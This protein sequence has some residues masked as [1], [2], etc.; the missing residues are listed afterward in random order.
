MV[1]SVKWVV[2]NLKNQGLT[3]IWDFSSGR[4]GWRNAAN[5]GP[6]VAGRK[7]DDD[8]VEVLRHRRRRRRR[9]VARQWT[10]SAELSSAW[11]RRLKDLRQGHS[12]RKLEFKSK[13]N[14]RQAKVFGPGSFVQMWFDQ[15]TNDPL[16]Q[17]NDLLNNFQRC[18]LTTDQTYITAKLFKLLAIACF[19][20]RGHFY[21]VLSCKLQL[22]NRLF[23][24]DHRI[25]DWP[26]Y[27]CQPSGFL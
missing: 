14:L 7:S 23:A 9:R 18:Q 3:H 24:N 2:Y 6:I 20:T 17:S 25:K 11:G 19:C 1:I 8:D 4:L 13:T 21:E 15:I 10:I 12:S 22:V 26:Y 5:S 27:D 16:S